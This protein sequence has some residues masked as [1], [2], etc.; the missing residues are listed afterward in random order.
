MVF[1]KV[2]VNDCTLTMKAREN[3]NELRGKCAN[4]LTFR[5]C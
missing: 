3:I 5:M 1:R 2:R 4:N